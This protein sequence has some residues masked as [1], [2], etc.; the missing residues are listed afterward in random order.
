[1]ARKHGSVEPTQL[2]KAGC[3]VR[4]DPEQLGDDSG[5]DFSEAEKLL[6]SDGDSKPDIAP[7]VEKSVTSNVEIKNGDVAQPSDSPEGCERKHSPDTK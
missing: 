6:A 1:M 3:G 7:V 2:V 4:F 5:F